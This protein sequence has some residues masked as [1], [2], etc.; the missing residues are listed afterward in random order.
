MI[1]EAPPQPPAQVCRKVIT[2]GGKRI[3]P[4]PRK[5]VIERLPALPCK[6]QSVLIERWLPYAQQ[7]RRVIFQGPQCQCPVVCPPKNVV[8]QWESPKAKVKKEVKYLG[9][10]R[11]NPAE[12]VDQYGDS[13][14][15][16]DALPD[17]VN[18]VPTPDDLTLAAD[19]Q[20]NE[21]H[22][23]EG[24]VDALKL[25]NLD[26]EGLSA[27]AAF[28]SSLPGQTVSLFNYNLLDLTRFWFE[29]ALSGRFSRV[30]SIAS[31]ST[32]SA[33]VAVSSS[34]AAVPTALSQ[35]AR[36]TPSSLTSQGSAQSNNTSG[37][38]S[39]LLNFYFKQKLLLIYD[40]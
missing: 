32:A 6:P 25:I 39:G 7:K 31:A 2:I 35:L 22:E 27:Y 36:L 40:F 13:L 38:L 33:S 11:A 30:S 18:E 3:P 26:T 9:V 20:Q 24:D 37:W 21:L 10:I 12:Y 17:I 34:A 15:A 29:K 16:S 14:L 19:A 1:R 4:P 23:L 28:V 5:V 8:V